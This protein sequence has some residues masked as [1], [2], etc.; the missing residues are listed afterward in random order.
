MVTVIPAPF[1]EYPSP[2]ATS[3]AFDVE[4]K[5]PGV[6][7]V[8]IFVS[9]AFGDVFVSQRFS[10]SELRLCTPFMMFATNTLNLL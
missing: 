4:S 10:V 7:V 5:F 3:T 6:A 1:F 9:A 8:S 2:A